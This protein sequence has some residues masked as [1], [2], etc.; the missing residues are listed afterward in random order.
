MAGKKQDASQK[1]LIIILEIMIKYIVI[2]FDILNFREFK[3]STEGG[4]ISFGDN[5]QG[6]SAVYLCG[7]AFIDKDAIFIKK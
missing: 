1:V 6:C 4:F 3:Y 2:E 5:L 7:P